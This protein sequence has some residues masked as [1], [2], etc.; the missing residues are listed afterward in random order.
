MRIRIKSSWLALCL[1]GT[2]NCLCMRL[3]LSLF[4]FVCLCLSLSVSYCLGLSLFV[5]VCVCPSCFVSACLCLSQCVCLGVLVCFV[6]FWL[7]VSSNY[8]RDLVWQMLRALSLL[9]VVLP[10]CL[11]PSLLVL[12]CLSL[13]ASAFDFIPVNS[14]FYIHI[15]VY[16]RLWSDGAELRFWITSKQRRMTAA[17]Q[18]RVQGFD[19]SKIKPLESRRAMGQLAGNAMRKV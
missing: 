1:N 12:D 9:S 4:V 17:E 10:L 18:F 7:F 15:C 2:W 13:S 6:C 3:C 14:W 11:R 19:T 8:P 16:D 5:F